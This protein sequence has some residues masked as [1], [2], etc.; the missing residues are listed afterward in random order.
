MSPLC[1]SHTQTCADSSPE[2]IWL[3]FL[4]YSAAQRGC[5]WPARH[6]SISRSAVRC[7]GCVKRTATTP[8]A[9][10]EQEQ[11]AV[12]GCRGASRCARAHSAAPGLAERIAIL[13]SGHVRILVVPVSRREC[14]GSKAIAV[15][16]SSGR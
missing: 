9:H 10:A 15:I 8:S 14:S 11:A 4:L 16:L 6:T 13:T 1:M 3:K 2:T 12:Q 5:S 7:G